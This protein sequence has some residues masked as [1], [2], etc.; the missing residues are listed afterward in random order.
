MDPNINLKEI[1]QKF[2]FG[3][4]TGY[5]NSC[6]D[7]FFANSNV[8]RLHI[9]LHDAAGSVKS[10][11]CKGPGYYY[12]LPSFPS[13]CFVGHVSGLFF[14]LYVKLFVSSVYALFDF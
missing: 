10:T 9:V 2:P 4:L 1:D 6:M 14:C 5:A 13:S 7:Y 3:G 8:F 11:T 12:V